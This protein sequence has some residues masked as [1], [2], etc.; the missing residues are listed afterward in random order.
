[1]QIFVHAVLLLEAPM[2]MRVLLA[3][4]VVVTSVGIGG[5][6]AAPRPQSAGPTGEL[7]PIEEL[8]RLLFWDPILS[9][10]RT[11]ACASCHHPNFAYTDGR[12]LPLGVGALGIGPDRR[13]ATNGQILP[14]RRNA[15]TLLNAALNGL[16]GRRR[17]RRSE[18][19][20]R[21]ELVD[22]ASAPMF[23][24]SRTRSLES[25][26]LE[27]LRA[28]DEMRGDVYPEEEAVDSVVMRLRSVPEYVALF[29][30]A[31]GTQ[32]PLEAA[33]LGAAIAAFER[34]LVA[35]NSPLD[36]FRA[37]DVDALTPVQRR[38]LEE[39]QQAGCDECHS[40]P[41][42]SDYD[43]RTLGVAE[44]S[45][46]SDPDTG[47][48]RFR[49]RTPSLR[50]VALTAPYMHNGTLATLDDVL[51]FYDNG[52]SE[53]P[54]VA[55]RRGNREGGQVATV[56]NDFRRVDNLS[57]GE[58]REIIAFLEALTDPEFDR[59]IPV[60]VPSGLPPGGL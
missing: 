21:L 19:A 55:T 7:L 38:G 49:F 12:A 26:A 25:Q 39:F 46:V 11:V 34:T 10:D 6:V 36:R 22:Q 18:T 16:E 60:R 27:P 9:G 30:E 40:G 14:V 53:N 48:G 56:D 47:A 31:F 42:F 58:I 59:T 3:S 4:L 41:M 1:M 2:K 43:L 54:A 24:D 32:Q 8:G 13:D 35:V 45:A 51:R 44:N 37:G 33:Q 20:P 29:A 17:G 28:F 5:V 52:R 50:N 15:P 23:W 57:E